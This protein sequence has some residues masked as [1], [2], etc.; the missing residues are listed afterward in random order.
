MRLPQAVNRHTEEG[1]RYEGVGDALRRMWASEGLA[2]FYRGMQVKLAQTVLAA[3]LMMVLKEEIYEWTR[4][5]LLAPAAIGGGAGG[6]KGGAP[7]AA[8]AG[9]TG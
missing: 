1:M 4:A 5:L 6:G 2:G 3:A 9:R 7:A 8:R